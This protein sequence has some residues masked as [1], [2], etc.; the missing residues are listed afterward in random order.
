MRKGYQGRVLSHLSVQD[1]YLDAKAENI[2]LDFEEPY[3]TAP[4]GGLISIHEKGYQ[5]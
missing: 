4:K 1:W 5:W 2:F 3:R